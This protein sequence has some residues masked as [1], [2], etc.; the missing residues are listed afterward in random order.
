MNFTKIIDSYKIDG[1]TITLY[2]KFHLQSLVETKLLESEEFY[3]EFDAYMKSISGDAL[4]SYINL[5]NA[6]G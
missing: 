5:L 4:I 1:T 2:I 3:N 6:P